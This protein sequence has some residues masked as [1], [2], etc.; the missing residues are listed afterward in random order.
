MVVSSAST[1]RGAWRA[2]HPTIFAVL[3]LVAHDHLVQETIADPALVDH[4]ERL[5]AG[6]VEVLPRTVRA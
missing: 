5:G 4:V 3:L 6:L 1:R 2:W